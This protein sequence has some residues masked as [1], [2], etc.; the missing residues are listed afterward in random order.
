MKFLLD[1]PWRLPDCWTN[2][3]ALTA[4]EDADRIRARGTHPVPF[5]EN[6]EVAEWMGALQ[7]PRTTAFATVMRLVG[8]Y[9]RDTPGICRAT[10]VHALPR[11]RES[12]E[13]ALGDEMALSSWRYPQIVILESH[14]D[15]WPQGNEIG[16]SFHSCEVQYEYGP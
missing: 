6:D 14:K 1:Y 3:Q 4:F 10:P 5:F 8:N 12:W 13:R 15:D 11:L 2:V 16:V 7:G 9:C